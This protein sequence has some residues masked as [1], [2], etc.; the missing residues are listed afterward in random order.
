ME[1]TDFRK[2]CRDVA[3]KTSSTVEFSLDGSN[4]TALFT[5]PHSDSTRPT[6]WMYLQSTGPWG[7]QLQMWRGRFIAEQ[8]LRGVQG[9]LLCESGN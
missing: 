1:S 7:D 9:E 4:D 2:M 3:A 6:W 5:R 8:Q